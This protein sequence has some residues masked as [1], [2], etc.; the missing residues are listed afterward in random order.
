MGACAVNWINVGYLACARCSSTGALVLTEPVST[1]NSRDQPLSPPKAERCPN[2]S[3][4]GKV[5]LASKKVVTIYGLWK[6]KEPIHINA[7]LGR[8]FKFSWYHIDPKLFFSSP[9][10]VQHKL[11][12]LKFACPR[13]SCCQAIL[14]AYRVVW[15]Y[16]NSLMHIN[17]A[18]HVPNMSLYRNGNGKWTWSPDWP[19]WLIMGFFPT[20][21]L[22]ISL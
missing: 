6:N 17:F 8:H 10:Y 16:S 20:N 19:F 15:N 13:A 22:V 1:V 9:F 12:T 7:F 5:R 11:F 21:L 3:G 4:S 14:L 18:G 2:C